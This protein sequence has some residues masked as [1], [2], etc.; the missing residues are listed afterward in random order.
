MIGKKLNKI[1]GIKVAILIFVTLFCSII[2]VFIYYSKSTIFYNSDMDISNQENT[3]PFLKKSAVVNPGVIPSIDSSK[4]PLNS[5]YMADWISTNTAI[6][7]LGKN[8]SNILSVKSITPFNSSGQAFAYE[9]LTN[10]DS[11]VIQYVVNKNGVKE[12]INTG[13][14]AVKAKPL[15]ASIT[16]SSIAIKSI[17][18]NQFFIDKNLLGIAIYFDVKLKTWKYIIRTDVGDVSM[19]I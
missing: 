6:S 7:I 12:R 18:T 9:I 14:K 11:F 17:S 10:E 1:V 8:R 4:T 2:V 3:E 19:S 13:I 15:P 5:P 16:D